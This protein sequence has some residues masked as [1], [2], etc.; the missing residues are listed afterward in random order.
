M[1]PDDALT[2]R[3]RSLAL[4]EARRYGDDPWV[5]LRE[6]VQNARDAGAARVEVEVS[7][8]SGLVAV[9]CRDDGD[10]MTWTRAREALFTLYAS[11]KPR[12][13]AGRFGVGF[14]SVLRF[15]PARITIASRARGAPRGWRVT[16]S[17]R[18][19][20]GG[21]VH[22]E[23]MP[24]GTE[25]RLE[26]RASSGGSVDEVR[27]V[28]V[29]TARHARRLRQPEKLLEIRCNGE[30]ISEP[31]PTWDPGLEFRAPGVRG[32]V[33][34]SESPTVE[35]LAHGLRVRT[36]QTLDELVSPS[37]GASVEG[38]GDPSARIV[39]DC[40]R[41]GV[42][43]SRRDVADSL[44]VRRAVAAAQRAFDELVRRTAGRSRWTTAPGRIIRATP[45]RVGWCAAALV[46]LMVAA[47]VLG[48]VPRWWPAAGSATAPGAPA[49]PVLQLFSDR[50]GRYTGPGLEGLPVPARAPVLTFRPPEQTLFFGAFRLVG[51]GEDGTPVRSA[52]T[53]PAPPVEPTQSAVA[54]SL[55][56]D[57]RAGRHRI[58][59]P[60]GHGLVPDS[61]RLD[62]RPVARAAFV[63]GGDAWLEHPEPAAG[64]LDYL[65]VPDAQSGGA[66]PWPVPG[67]ALRSVSDRLEN[68]GPEQAV[69]R[70]ERT[71]SEVLAYRLDSE[72]AEA[73]DAAR[74]AGMP[75]CEAAEAAGGGDC[76]VVNG[77]LAA[78]LADA[79][80]T[81]RLAVGWVGRAGGIQPPLHA[82]VELDAGGRWIVGDATSLQTGPDTTGPR[83]TG[84][85][86]AEDT[87]APAHGF[88]IFWTVLGALVLALAAG[89]ER[90]R[91]K[92]SAP[93][94][95]AVRR[96]GR[97]DLALLVGR[98]LN[99]ATRAREGHQLWRERLVPLAGGGRLT[100]ARV[101]ELARTGRL[102]V[103]SSGGWR[104]ATVLDSRDRVARSAAR[105]VGAVDL[106]RWIRLVS[107]CH[108]DRITGFVNRLFE[109]AGAGLRLGLHPEAEAAEAVLIA[110]DGCR[111]VLVDPD[112]PGW[113]E[114]AREPVASAPEARL[115]AAIAERLGAR[116]ALCAWVRRAA[117]EFW[118]ESRGA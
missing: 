97:G 54:V 14:W 5:F 95:T 52:I 6:L 117:L 34:F 116:P 68:L 15:E 93:R 60:T 71:V 66:G 104:G 31:L 77:V 1:S 13:A 75:F 102:A 105:A 88:V 41:L 27:S 51:L 49:P 39:L 57:E 35:L 17:D 3:F 87:A 81:V 62:G 78:V 2:D 36:A 86:R 74:R 106:D 107:E 32:V 22:D 30:L 16:L 58:P 61:V 24:E 59:I 38:L 99:G 45:A 73:F 63:G 53:Q 56:V 11:D 115:A 94:L 37:G 114:F 69:E 47:G 25:I 64:R 33:G 112:A 76:D 65:V 26:R 111:W 92:S 50:A 83:D 12:G 18:L 55:V 79:G 103:G 110:V 113:Q 100:P 89:L 70:A 48:L 118:L 21:L 109:R 84:P 10:G 44:E 43:M 23:A 28:L 29:R 82:W 101:V 85:V 4:R 19:E 90:R 20:A 46:V 72:T 98:L 96:G 108:Q 42:L 67:P 9:V 7:C 91:S 40:D 80:W 8:D